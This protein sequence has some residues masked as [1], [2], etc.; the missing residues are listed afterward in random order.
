MESDIPQVFSAVEDPALRA[1]FGEANRLAVEALQ[2]L[3]AWLAD[4]EQ[5][6]TDDFAIGGEL[7]TEMLRRTEG[8]EIPLDRIREAGEQDLERNLAALDAA[9]A[10]FSPGKSVRACI[11]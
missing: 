1:E 2:S 4:Q 10:K 6:A 3:D 11:P 8:V 7:F 5:E 9:C